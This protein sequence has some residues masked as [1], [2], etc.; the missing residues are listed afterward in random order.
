MM[1]KGVKPFKKIQLYNIDFRTDPRFERYDSSGWAYS[2]SE[3][4]LLLKMKHRAKEE[5][6]RI[7]YQLSE[8]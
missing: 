5:H 1:I 4:T 3:Q 6:I 2:E 8:Q 7:F